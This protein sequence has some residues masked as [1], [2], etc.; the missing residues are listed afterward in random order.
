MRGRLEIVVSGGV[1]VS[2]VYVGVRRGWIRAY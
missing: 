1:G 2:N